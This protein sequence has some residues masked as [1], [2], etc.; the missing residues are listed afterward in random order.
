MY[1]LKKTQYCLK[2][3]E[4]QHPTLDTR[5]HALF[6]PFRRSLDVS[7]YSALTRSDS[8]PDCVT[9]SLPVLMGAFMQRKIGREGYPLPVRI[10]FSFWKRSKAVL[11]LP[12]CYRSRMPA[13]PWIYSGPL[14]ILGREKWR[15]GHGRAHF[16]LGSF[17]SGFVNLL[18]LMEFW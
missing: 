16:H 7:G 4:I 10:T 1:P 5:D 14:K 2:L 13:P 6:L 12:S 3:L 15:T 9:A 17:A 11:I 8:M 18:G